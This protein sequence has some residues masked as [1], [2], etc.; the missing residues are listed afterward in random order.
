M[1]KGYKTTA[2][3]TK[4]KPR[5]RSSLSLSVH[6]GHPPHPHPCWLPSQL[7]V[8]IMQ[9]NSLVLPQACPSCA[10]HPAFH[11]L[12]QLCLMFCFKIPLSLINVKPRE[13][14]LERDVRVNGYDNKHTYLCFNTICTFPLVHNSFVHMLSDHFFSKYF[15]SKLKL[16]FILKGKFWAQ[17]LQFLTCKAHQP[18]PSLLDL[19]EWALIRD[20]QM[21]SCFSRAHNWIK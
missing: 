1:W 2:T 19:V 13:I 7:K 18:S 16:M 11:P 9:K 4:N 8:V 15:R 6:G 12:E 10:P 5:E 14:R 17:K 3:A 20:R 21:W